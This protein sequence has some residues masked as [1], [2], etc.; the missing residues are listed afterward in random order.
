LLSI[1]SEKI[2]AE[3]TLEKK[4]M[5]KQQKQGKNS[6]HFFGNLSGYFVN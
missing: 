2:K 6:P 5:N 3:N 4:R 1:L